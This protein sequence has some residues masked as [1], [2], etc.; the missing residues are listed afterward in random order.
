VP[1]SSPIECSTRWPRAP[2]SRT[3]GRGGR[4]ITIVTGATSG[5]AEGDFSTCLI[6]ASRP[7]IR[8]DP[9]RRVTN[10]KWGISPLPG[11]HGEKR[12]SDRG[13]GLRDREQDHRGNDPEVAYRELSA[14]MEYVRRSAAVP[15][16]GD[17]SRLY[18]HSSAS[19]ANRLNDEADCIVG[20]ERRLEERGCSRASRWT[21]C[22]RTFAAE[23]LPRT[24]RSRRSRSQIRSPSTITCSASGDLVR[25]GLMTTWSSHPHGPP[26]REERHGVTDVSR[27]CRVRRWAAPSRDAGLKTAWNSAARRAR[28]VGTSIGLGLAGCRT[29]RRSSSATTPSTPSDLLKPRRHAALGLQRRLEIAPSP[30]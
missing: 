1:V 15:A 24:S 3:S 5:T 25:G 4:G 29:W 28:R 27:G 26:R 23:L 19:G 17:V 11:Q 2:P 9:D 8:C 13:Q 21:G 12:I 20:F 7:A 14:A 22:A 10:N 6:W 16:R 30:S 18:G